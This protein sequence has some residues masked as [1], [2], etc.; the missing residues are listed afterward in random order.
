MISDKKERTA[1]LVSLVACLLISVL[2]ISFFLASSSQAVLLDGAFNILFFGLGILTL[3]VQRLVQQPSS[4]QFP[5]GYASFEPLLNTFKGLTL[6]GVSGMALLPAVRAL[7]TGG[8]VMDPG[9]GAVYGGLAAVIASVVALL[10]KRAA[11][12]TQSPL[13]HA[14]AQNWIAN[15][16]VSAA[17]ALAFAGVFF[18]RARGIAWVVPYVDP[19]IVTAVVLV[20][21]PVPIEM[22]RKGVGELLLQGPDEA[23]QSR[24]VECVR[25][26]IPRDAT[27]DVD[28]R[29]AR[30][31]RRNFVSVCCLVQGE[32]EPVLIAE[33]DGV[34]EAIRQSLRRAD[35]TATVDVTFTTS[36]VWSS[37]RLSEGS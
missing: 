26:A 15:A 3:R 34:R 20:T 12:L 17:V 30:V 27:V 7:F 6:L 9:L 32:S 21:L 13:V 11:R 35:P 37:D 2:A 25:G 33:L 28:L 8:R 16:T 24:F 4:R 14:D 36:P 29:M 31:G 5:Y 22:I 1:L 18:A 10:Q 23:T 19:T